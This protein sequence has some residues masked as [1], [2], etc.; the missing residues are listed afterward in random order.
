MV[1]LELSI[2]SW[3]S[4]CNPSI[5]P[6]LLSYLVWLLYLPLASERGCCFS[7]ARWNFMNG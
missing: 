7:L 4:H 3:I 1:L 6:G 2:R 5:N